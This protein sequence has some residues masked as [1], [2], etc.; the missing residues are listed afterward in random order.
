MINPIYQFYIRLGDVATEYATRPI[1]KDDLSIDFEQESGQ[2]FFR[3]KVNGK[4][5]FLREDY[6]LIMNAP[7][8]TIYHLIIKKSDDFG[9]SWQNYWHGKFMRTD[10]TIDEFDKT[11][12]VQPSITDEYTEVLAGLEKEYNLIELAPHMETLLLTK[13]P[14]IQVYKKGDKM[15]SCFLS[16][17]N[18]EQEVNERV[19]NISKLIDKYHFAKTYENITAAVYGKGYGVDTTEYHGTYNLT[20]TQNNGNSTT[21]KLVRSDNSSYTMELQINRNTNHSYIRILKNGEVK[22]EQYI[23]TNVENDGIHDVKNK[24]KQDQF[25]THS[26]NVEI[27]NVSVFS[28]L[29][30]DKTSIVGKNTYPLASDDLVENNRNYRYAIGYNMG[31]IVTTSRGSKEP[32]EYGKREDGLYFT[33]PH[34]IDKFYP[35]GKNTWNMVSFWFKFK[36]EDTFAE[37]EGRS[38]IELK[39][40]YELGSCIDVL[41]QKIS[42]VR[43]ESNATCSQFLY[44]DVNPISR[45]EQ[46]LF[47]TPKSN[48]IISEYQ[49][50]AQKAVCTLQTIFSML[51]D[52][53]RCY[54]FIEDKKLH[55]EHISYFNNGGT[56]DG[57]AAIGYDLTSL[58]NPRNGKPWSFA[59]GEYSFDKSDM[60]ERYQFKWMD[61][62]TEPFDGFPIEI[63][64]N[65]VQKG[66][67]EEINVGSFSSDVDLIMLN[68]KNISK[69][70]FVVMAAVQATATNNDHNGYFLHYHNKKDGYIDN[71]YHIKKGVRGHRIKLR[72][73]AKK[74]VENGV[75]Q[76]GLW[77]DLI[78]CRGDDKEGALIKIDPSNEL[79]E[80]FVDIPKDV[81]SIIFYSH[82]WMAMAVVDAKVVDGL[83]ELPFY[84]KQIDNVKY[85][86]QNG[87]MSF[88]YLQEKFYRHD[89]P[90]RLIIMNKE[91]NHAIKVD[92]KKKQTITFPTGFF[93][94]NPRKLVKTL[95]GNGQFEKISVNLCNRTI[96]ATLK[97]DTE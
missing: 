29:L 79:Q 84:A 14:L 33:P 76:N 53:C 31:N 62:C 73:Y 94:P 88:A 87:Y 86:L 69:D 38:D 89:L 52:T 49:D 16:G 58:K 37:V 1:Y 12:T 47:I 42:D 27:T 50:P 13:R 63:K 35:I 78:Y 36:F 61:D 65:Y 9:K 41:L 21:H 56:Y 80:V 2:K 64:S 24:P 20:D 54:W 46:R 10:C 92:K 85:A 60:A 55:I 19:D 74:H 71:K 93:D 67:I 68:P 4:L 23:Y 11:L 30:L 26:V 5:T 17:S 15:V 6:A 43:F 82:G 3:K 91:Y 59:R 8:D 75:E 34:N 70:G 90:A 72:M 51:R 45:Q 96:K 44:G 48:I 7:F 28:R 32:T 97:Y 40:A 25:V 39:N 81:D 66:K 95:L 77:L 57:Q 83:R 18:W 22:F